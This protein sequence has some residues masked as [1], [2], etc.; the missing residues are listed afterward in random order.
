MAKLNER[1]IKHAPIEKVS[2]LFVFMEEDCL[3]Q[4]QVSLR[5]GKMFHGKVF[6]KTYCNSELS[7]LVN[8]NKILS[9]L[10]RS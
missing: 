3:P 7:F 6:S 10:K 4:S 8:F 1:V 9:A 2:P 5:E